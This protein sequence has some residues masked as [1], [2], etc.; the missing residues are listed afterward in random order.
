MNVKYHSYVIVPLKFNETKKLPLEPAAINSMDVT[1]NVKE[2]FREGAPSK[3]CS[4]YKCPPII[5][6]GCYLFEKDLS[7][8]LTESFCLYSRRRLLFWR[9]ESPMTASR[10]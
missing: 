3:M 8:H 9:W 5:D 10:H 4:A 6:E 7:F 2:L 1:E